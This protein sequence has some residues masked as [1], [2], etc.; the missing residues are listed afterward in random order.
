MQQKEAIDPSDPEVILW[1]ERETTF[2]KYEQEYLDKIAQ[3]GT[4]NVNKERV[5]QWTM[6]VIKKM[7]AEHGEGVSGYGLKAMPGKD[8]TPLRNEE[9]MYIIDTRRNPTACKTTHIV[10]A[11]D[12]TVAIGR[13]YNHSECRRY[14][15]EAMEDVTGSNQPIHRYIQYPATI[16]GDC[17]AYHGELIETKVLFV[18]MGNVLNRTYFGTAIDPFGLKEHCFGLSFIINFS[19]LLDNNAMGICTAQTSDVIRHFRQNFTTSFMSVKV[20]GRARTMTQQEKGQK[21]GKVNRDKQQ[22]D[23]LEAGSRDKETV[24]VAS[25]DKCE[26]AGVKTTKF[27]NKVNPH[28]RCKLC[29]ETDRAKNQHGNWT[30]DEEP[31]PQEDCKRLHAE[32]KQCKYHRVSYSSYIL[33][34]YS[35]I[36]ASPHMSQQ[37]LLPRSCLVVSSRAQVMM[38]ELPNARRSPSM[39]ATSSSALKME[40]DG[41]VTIG[42]VVLVAIRMI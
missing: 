3:H 39:T 1:K 37:L 24:Y 33:N 25:C 27:V 15:E 18:V 34:L 35:S 28:V 9:M 21:S 14:D 11:G 22:L 42:G 7:V 13:H 12:S 17:G 41:Y 16:Q 26:D 5:I 20:A 6:F 29:K 2:I 31:L 23:L 4:D 38:I 19:E 32:M 40:T 30:V 8:G 36:S 10:Q